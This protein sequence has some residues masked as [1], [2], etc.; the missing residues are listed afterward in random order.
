MGL[1]V[2]RIHL[3]MLTCPDQV[4]LMRFR[5]FP[6]RGI[7]FY[8]GPIN[9]QNCT[10]RKFAA[11][12]GRHTSALAFRLNNAWQSC[13]NN[14]VTA[15]RFED[16]PV[17]HPPQGG[18]DFSQIFVPGKRGWGQKKEKT[19]GLADGLRQKSRNE[20]KEGM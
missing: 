12:D 4:S 16:V 3:L 6:I 15:L 13:P 11:L 2:S 5:D 14:N 9:V 20:R 10:F 8:D 18:V 1:C 19:S 7:Q 17:S